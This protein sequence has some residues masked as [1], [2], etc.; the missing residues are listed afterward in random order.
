MSAAEVYAAVD[1]VNRAE[2]DIV[3][4]AY[5]REDIYTVGPLRINIEVK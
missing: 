3:L 1:K 2:G 4:Q 5:T